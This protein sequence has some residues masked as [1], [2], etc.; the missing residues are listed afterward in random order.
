[1][2]TMNTKSKPDLVLYNGRITTLDP[3]NPEATN[4]AV[5]N[6][7]IVGVNDA[8]EYQRGPGTAGIDLNERRVIPGLNDSHRANQH[9]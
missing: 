6:G 2:N 1:M 3:Q 4:L 9:H 5:K 8:E 7:R